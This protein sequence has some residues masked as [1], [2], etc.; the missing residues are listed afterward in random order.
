MK[1]L[2]HWLVLSLLLAAAGG[3]LF[4][5]KR[6]VLGYPLTPGE[7][8]TAWTVQTRVQFKGD[9]GPLKVTLRLPAQ[10]PG[11]ARLN[12]HFVSRDFGLTVE[13]RQLART[14]VWAKRRVSGTQTLYYRATFYPTGLPAAL[15]PSPNYPPLPALDEPFATAL[16]NIVSKV[17]DHSADIASFSA[18]ML[19]RLNSGDPDEDFQLFLSDPVYRADRVA[20]ARLLLAGA[21]IPTLKVNGLKLGVQSNNLP[22]LPYLAVHNEQH[23][24]FFDPQSGQLGLPA[25]YLVLWFGDAPATGIEGGEVLGVRYA[26]QSSELSSLQLAIENTGLAHPWL[27]RFSLLA[28]PLHSQSLFEV[29]L[30][31]PVGAF[32]IVLLRNVVGVRSFGTFMPVLIAL[33]FRETRLLAG[34]L[35]FALIVG[36]GLLLRFYLE[37]LKLLLVPRLAA[38]LTIVVMLMAAISII[39]YQLNLEVGLSVALFPMVIMAMVIERMSI[40][41]E[42]SGPR[43][44]L[45]DAA[46]SL[47]IAALAYLTMENHLVRHLVLVYPELLLVM[48]GAIIALGRYTGYRLS[49]LRRFKPLAEGG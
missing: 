17:R 41:W 31:V 11:F 16:R 19:R 48:L 5:Y 22:P 44:A 46:G 35:M 43:N 6:Q 23:W 27:A 47:A 30:L 39:T 14:A 9:G 28:L 25:D 29:L 33:A 3:G 8:S 49:E 1:T 24:L 37:R 7:V 38:I 21:R 32:I 18:E 40:A 10:T 2:P 34:I 45:I 42:E 36:T 4:A 20:L 26:V 15:P 13:K 12:E